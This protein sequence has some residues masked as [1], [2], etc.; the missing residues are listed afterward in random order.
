MGIGVIGR[1]LLGM[2]EEFG[3]CDRVGFGVFALGKWVKGNW[4]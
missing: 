2:W 3:I 4:G 1:N